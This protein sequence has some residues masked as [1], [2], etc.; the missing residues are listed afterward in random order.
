MLGPVRFAHI[1]GC[2]KEAI[3]LARAGAI[4]DQVPVAAKRQ[5][6]GGALDEAKR[7]ADLIKVLSQ[8][9]ES[10]T[11]LRGLLAEKQGREKS[12]A[13]AAPDYGKMGLA[14]LEKLDKARDA[15]IAWVLKELDKA[16]EEVRIRDEG[17]ELAEVVLSSQQNG[18]DGGQSTAETKSVDK[19]KPAAEDTEDPVGVTKKLETTSDGKS[20]VYRGESPAAGDD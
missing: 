14:V 7:K 5:K 8:R 4:T 3:N 16:E 18:A 1:E 6:V 13:R 9:D 20:T 15:T 11:V 10:I 17:D 12:E 2:A 19:E